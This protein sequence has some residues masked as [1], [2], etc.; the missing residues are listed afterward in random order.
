MAL[1][2]LIGIIGVLV[3]I[4]VAFFIYD[5]YTS[6][7]WR[8]HCAK[9]RKDN[10]RMQKEAECKKYE[11]II[12]KDLCSQYADIHSIKFKK[13]SV[14]ALNHVSYVIEINQ[15][16]YVDMIYAVD[17]TNNKVGSVRYNPGKLPSEGK[18]KYDS[19][20]IT[21]NFAGLGD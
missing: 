6:R 16:Q 20:K 1:K 9:E 11:N 5:D 3:I 7:D 4:G 13:I 15:G 8:E 12:V 18:S 14:E 17:C 2:K 19:V 21:Y 10:D